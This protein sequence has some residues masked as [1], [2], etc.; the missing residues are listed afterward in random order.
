MSG[1][2]YLADTNAV[3]YFL[4][5]NECMRPYDDSYVCGHNYTGSDG[6]RRRA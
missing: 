4:S 3:L 6:L 2:D 5:G 1:I